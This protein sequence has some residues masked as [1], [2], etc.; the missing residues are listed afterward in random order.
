MAFAIV[1]MMAPRLNFFFFWRV[2][3]SDHLFLRVSLFLQIFRAH[4]FCSTHKM[5]IA[6]EEIESTKSYI[7]GLCSAIGGLEEIKLPDGSVGQVYCP[8]DEAL[9]TTWLSGLIKL[10]Y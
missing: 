1:P 7:L 10:F 6:Q 5:D 4:V 9:G 8:G 3:I 2:L